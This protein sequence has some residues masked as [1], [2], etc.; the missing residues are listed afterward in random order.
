LLRLSITRSYHPQLV[1]LV[2][3]SPQSLDFPQNGSL[4]PLWDTLPWSAIPR[5]VHTSL[6]RVLAF[7]NDTKLIVSTD[8]TLP[9]QGIENITSPPWNTSESALTSNHSP[10]LA[11]SKF[12]RV[13][14]LWWV[15]KT[16]PSFNLNATTFF[17]LEHT[18]RSFIAVVAMNKHQLGSDQSNWMRAYAR[19]DLR[20]RSECLLPLVG[21][22]VAGKPRL[23]PSARRG[24]VGDL[25]SWRNKRTGAFVQL[26]A[27]HV[28]SVMGS[29]LV[30][31]MVSDLCANSLAR[32]WTRAH[33]CLSVGRSG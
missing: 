32:T 15:S 21:V 22:T 26:S 7:L 6:C 28:N 5:S 12:T 13:P 1:S 8:W 31:Q 23:R 19:V 3:H 17:C 30:I 24:T 10:T 2:H 9:R 27:R 29:L 16:C 18:Y 4:T 11:P 14:D 33:L 25:E 20:T